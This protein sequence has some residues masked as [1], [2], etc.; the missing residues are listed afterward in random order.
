LFL[1]WIMQRAL[2]ALVVG[3]I[4]GALGGAVFGWYVPIQPTSAKIDQLNPDYKSDYAVMV[5]AAYAVNHDWD[6]VQ[7]RLGYLAEPDPAGYIV[8]LTEQ[9]IAEGRSPDDIR[10]LTRLASRFGYTTP[11]M[12]PYL[13][14]TPAGSN[15]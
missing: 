9:Y 15:P 8:L 1:E 13:P 6:L 4:L 12:L 10:N 3:L 2:L 5:G 11:P 7:T 14:P